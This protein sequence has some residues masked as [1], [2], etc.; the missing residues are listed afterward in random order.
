[1]RRRRLPRVRLAIELGRLETVVSLASVAAGVFLVVTVLHLLDGLA[2]ELGRQMEGVGSRTIFVTKYEQK[3]RLRQRSAEERHRPDLTRVEAA[4]LATRCEALAAVSPERSVRTTARAGGATATVTLIG[5]TAAYQPA[6]EAHPREG[7]FFTPGETHGGAPVCVVGAG[8]AKA[9]FGGGG[10]GEE[11]EVEGRRCAVIGVVA[12]RGSP[13]FGQGVD[14]FVLVPLPVFERLGIP[15]RFTDFV[16][17]VVPRPGVSAEEGQVAVEST[18]RSI[19]GLGAGDDNDFAVTPQSAL[20]AVYRQS[21]DVFVLGFLAVAAL[22]L[23]VGCAG[24]LTVMLALVSERTAE[25][26]LQ[27]AVGARRVDVFASFLAEGVVVTSLGGLG[28]AVL[29]QLGLLAFAL[30][31]RVS[32]EP[33]PGWFAFALGL[34]ALTGLLG[35]VLPAAAAARLQPA[36]ALH[37]E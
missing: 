7:R 5:G 31:F 19:R 28:G 16:V 37:H 13:L 3:L 18:L 35:G 23:L 21:V 9:L 1:M 33:S 2:A 15:D 34:A 17:A 32:I 4:A 22:S 14:N 27:R 25:I 12:R 36:V 30:L 29:S 20:L 6:H 11:I 26:G 24:I 10:V 8:V